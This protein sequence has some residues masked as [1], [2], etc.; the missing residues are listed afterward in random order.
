VGVSASVMLLQDFAKKYIFIFV[1]LSLSP[2]DEQ[3]SAV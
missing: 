1:S 2:E 3:V